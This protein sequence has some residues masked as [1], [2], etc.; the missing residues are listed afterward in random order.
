[1]P[2]QGTP[3]NCDAFFDSP[4]M[5]HEAAASVADRM[6]NMLAYQVAYAV[7]STDPNRF[8]DYE[9]SQDE[10]LAALT[11]WVSEI[12]GHMRKDMRLYLDYGPVVVAGR[13]HQRCP[14]CSRLL[15]NEP[16]NHADLA[17]EECAINACIFHPSIPA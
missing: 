2:A 1:M 17:W 11:E 16:R 14:G 10:F 6:G 12:L 8:E 4:E 9:A 13:T 7:L 5:C 3:V 15:D